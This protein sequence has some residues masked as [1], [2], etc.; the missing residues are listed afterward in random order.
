MKR[1][2]ASEPVLLSSSPVAKQPAQ[3]TARKAWWTR[4][5]WL[6]VAGIVLVASVA[7][8]VLLVRPGKAALIPQTIQ[9]QVAFP[10]YQPGWL[11]AGYTID[12]QSFD[13][14]SQVVT[15]SIT[16]AQANGKLV[17]TE[18][19]QPPQTNIDTFYTQQLTEV[20]TAQGKSGSVT[21]GQF[22]TSP[23]AGVTTGRTWVLLRSSTLDRDTLERIASNFEP[24]K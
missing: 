10:L 1:A 9:T 5:L 23:L 11:P 13:A 3:E 12:A 19:P 22:E 4:P 21:A 8:A 24:S 2:Y 20:R 16:N 17:V 15:F 7:I 14:T 18:Q 6:S